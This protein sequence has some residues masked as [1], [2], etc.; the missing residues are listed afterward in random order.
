[1]RRRKK[2]LSKYRRGTKLAILLMGRPN[3][4]I[5]SSALL[6]GMPLAHILVLYALRIISAYALPQIYWEATLLSITN[7]DKFLYSRCTKVEMVLIKP[8]ICESIFIIFWSTMNYFIT[9]FR[10][11]SVAHSIGSK[12][13]SIMIQDMKETIQVLQQSFALFLVLIRLYRK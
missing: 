3:S 7:S 2:Y 5:K 13:I 11:L 12:E 9:T 4:V 10:K 6:M 1:M 8:N